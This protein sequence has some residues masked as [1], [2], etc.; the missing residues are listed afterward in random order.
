MTV[1]L[2]P[3]PSQPLFFFQLNLENCRLSGLEKSPSTWP[4]F[5]CLNYLHQVAY[6]WI[7]LVMGISPPCTVAHSVHSSVFCVLNSLILSQNTSHRSFFL[8]SHLYPSALAGFTEVTEN[9]QKPSF[10]NIFLQTVTNS[11]RIR[12]SFFPSLLWKKIVSTFHHSKD[13]F[14]SPSAGSHWD[15]KQ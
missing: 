7:P 1:L 12:W 3:K 2:L 6:T 13:V 14:F 11:N 5:W 15:E 8:L 10:D 4:V 9:L